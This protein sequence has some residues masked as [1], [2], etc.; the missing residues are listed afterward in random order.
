MS[1]KEG[2]PLIDRERMY[3]RINWK[4]DYIDDKEDKGK[5]PL[6]GEDK[7]KK[8]IERGLGLKFGWDFSQ[9]LKVKITNP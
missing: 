4:C 9:E 2:D 7:E 6:S 8:G 1:S 3:L 5:T